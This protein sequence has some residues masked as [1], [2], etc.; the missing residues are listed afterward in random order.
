MRRNPNV[1]GQKLKCLVPKKADMENRC[2]QVSVPIAEVKEDVK[3]AK[4]SFPK[5]F[6]ESLDEYAAAYDEWCDAEGKYVSL[7]IP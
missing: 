6:R 2:F 1:P 5:A 7:F 3:E 4:N